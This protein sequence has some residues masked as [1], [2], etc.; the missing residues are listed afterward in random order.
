MGWHAKLHSIHVH[1]RQYAHSLK[2]DVAGNPVED[3]E[4]CVDIFCA[5]EVDGGRL[6]D[7]CANGGLHCVRVILDLP[8]DSTRDQHIV[9]SGRYIVELLR[10]DYVAS[11]KVD[12]VELTENII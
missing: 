3:I 9:E 8:R 10:S 1:I 5:R 7:E 11:I 6:G 2:C 12:W 4:H